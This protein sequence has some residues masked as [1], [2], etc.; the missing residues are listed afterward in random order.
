LNGARFESTGVVPLDDREFGST[1]PFLGVCMPEGVEAPLMFRLN[2]WGNWKI[3][4][5]FDFYSKFRSN[6]GQFFIEAPL[7]FLQNFRGGL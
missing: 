6:D 1:D 4:L 5:V 7:A 2:F 3:V